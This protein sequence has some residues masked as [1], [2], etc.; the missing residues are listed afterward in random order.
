MTTDEMFQ[1]LLNEVKDMRSDLNRLE[2]K[3]DSNQ[4]QVI[5]KIDANHKELSE[6]I[7]DL[8][9]QINETK[10]ILVGTRADV[11][12]LRDD[13]KRLDNQAY[14]VKLLDRTTANLHQRV[15]K[16]EDELEEIKDKLDK[17][18]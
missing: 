16:A 1:L 4:K 3:V 18:S 11:L 6:K 2:A 8:Q 13:V 5:E 14:S 17:A 15:G 10:I 12:D 9:V 7:Q